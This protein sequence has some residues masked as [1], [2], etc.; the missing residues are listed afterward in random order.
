MRGTLHAACIV[1]RTIGASCVAG[2]TPAAQ[3]REKTEEVS[4]SHDAYA[5]QIRYLTE[6]GPRA[7]GTP[8]HNALIDHVATALAELGLDVR[9]D[10]HTF[11]RWEVDRD[12]LALQVGER[13]IAI[14][15]AWPYSGETP[16]EGTT[17]PLVLLR[18]RRKHWRAAAGKIAVIEVPHIAV[19]TTLLVEAWDGPLP[20]DRVSNPIISSEL[21]GTDLAKAK[22]AGV[23]GV[24]A[25]WRGLPD[26]AA[27]GQYLPFTRGY[28]G[29]PAVWVAE[30]QRAQLLAAAER[31]AVATLTVSASKTA[32]ARMDTLWAVSPGTG[33]RASESVLV[34]THSDGGNAVEENGHIGL[35]ALARDAVAAPHERSIVFVYTAGHL[36]M[37]AVTAHGQATTAWLETHRDLWAGTPGGYTAAAGLVI[38]HLGAKHLRIDAATGRYASDGTLEPELLYATTPELARLTR[39]LWRGAIADAATPVKPGALLHFGEGEPLFERGIPAV[40]L[41]TG[42]EYLLAE[43]EGDLVDIDALARQVDSFRRLQQHLAGSI[44]RESFGKVA[45]PGKWKKA[46]AAVRVGVFLLR[47]R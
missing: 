19:P 9:R 35:L 28:Q 34:V 44:D 42:P 15:S 47:R 23:L 43:C 12:T 6:L 30:S 27:A 22:R 24:I 25:V 32:N 18:G 1:A 3:T 13:R 39:T 14:A 26:A 17:A 37:P 29:L 41:V 36:R 10:P 33:P 5:D 11:E 16:R 45:L 8:A 21:A 20:F 2:Y 7:S 40:A 46:L 31:G 38:E 4:A